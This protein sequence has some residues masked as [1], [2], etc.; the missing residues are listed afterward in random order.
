DPNVAERPGEGRDDN[1]RAKRDLAACLAP[2]CWGSSGLLR[3][4]EVAA[5]VVAV[6]AAGDFARRGKGEERG[7]FNVSW[8]RRVRQNLSFVINPASTTLGA[9]ASRC[10]PGICSTAPCIAPSAA[11]LDSQIVKAVKES[12][13]IRGYDGGKL[14]KGRKRRLLVDTVGLPIA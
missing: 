1:G 10:A 7:C 14:V 2:R 11:I 13:G 12:G 5:Q 3:G 8:H 9:S 4:A 6:P